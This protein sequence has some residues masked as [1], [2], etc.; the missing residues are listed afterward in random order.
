MVIAMDTAVRVSGRQGGGR[1]SRIMAEVGKGPA[2]D[3]FVRLGDANDSAFWVNVT[4]DPK[5]L[6]EDGECVSVSDFRFREY[7]D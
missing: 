2:G 4:I 1:V 7:S 3:I 6:P 5:L